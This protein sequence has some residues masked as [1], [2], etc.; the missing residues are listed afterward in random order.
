MLFLY[1]ILSAVG[2]LMAAL[3]FEGI[4]LALKQ[5]YR[6][7]IQKHQ[8]CWLW[9]SA[10]GVLSFAT[11]GASAL[12]QTAMVFCIAAGHIGLSGVKEGVISPM[13][14]VKNIPHALR[15]VYEKFRRI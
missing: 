9:W 11:G 10:L 5:D 15:G 13:E 14:I 4:Y 8:W 1:M 3:V 7:T 6:G 2:L 12:I